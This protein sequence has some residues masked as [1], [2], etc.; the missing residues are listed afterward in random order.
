MNFHKGVDELTGANLLSFLQGADLAIIGKENITDTLLA[1]VPKLRAISKYGVGM[2]KIDL[3]ACSK[4]GVTV[5]RREGVNADSVAEHTLALMLAVM[6]NIGQSDRRFHLGQWWKDGGRQ[7]TGKCVG[8]VGFGH[9]GS[10]VAKLLQAFRCQI[11]VNE[12]DE[13]KRASILAHGFELRE[14]EPLIK[15]SDLL[16]LHVPLDPS[17]FHLIN[18][19]NIRNFSPNAFLI[20]TSRGQVVEQNALKLALQT[21]LLAGAGLDVFEEEPVQ[22]PELSKL[23][24]LVATAHMAGNSLEAVLTMGEA[25][26]DCLVDFLRR[27]H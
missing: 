5:L 18:E 3:Q 8:I 21:G 9:V 6:R 7:L 11:L 15:D 19:R 23:E 22:D 10:R 14:L 24:N 17:T 13:G 20:N 1:Q 12:I 2:D 16:S 27:H 25:A 4:Y 26:I